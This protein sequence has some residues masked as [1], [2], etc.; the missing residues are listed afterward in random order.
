MSEIAEMPSMSVVKLNVT[1]A[2]IARLKEEYMPL[3]IAGI[4]DRAG[5]KKVYEARQTVKRTRVS[6]VKHADELKEQAIAWQKKVNTEKGRV[7]GELELIEKHLQSEEDRIDGEKEAIR[8]EAERI[9][10][11]RIQKRIDRLTEYGFAID[12]TF[13]QNIGDEDFEKVVDNAKSEW[14]KEQDA[15]AEAERLQRAEEARIKAER[16]ELEQ[17]RAEQAKAQAI[18]KA[19]NDRIAKEQADKEA[20]LNAE[21][22]RLEKEKADQEAKNK[23]AEEKIRRDAYDAEQKRL[24]EER[25]AKAREEAAEEARL[26]AVATA[27]REQE[28]KAEQDR[29]AKIEAERQAALRPD[30]EKLQMFS[31]GL[32]DL[33]IPAVANQAAQEIVNEITLMINKM[34]AHI[35]KKIKAL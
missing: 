2:E 34:Q 20:A 4:E 31:D 24:H 14:L 3:T 26:K 9:E 6:L 11:A 7:V 1:D 32:S 16:E 28:E 30:K 23:A 22:V 8:Q 35:I 19:E 33:K 10:K 17:L 21:V 15:K 27:K 25:V 5:Y 29:Q 13:V 12:Y 18:I